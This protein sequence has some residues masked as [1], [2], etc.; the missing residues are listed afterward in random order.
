M[1]LHRDKVFLMA[2]IAEQRRLLSMVEDHPIMSISH[3]IKID[4]LQNELDSMPLHSEE[5]SIELLFSGKAVVGSEGIKASFLDKILNPFQEL[6]KKKAVQIRYGINIKVS[7][8]RSAFAD[9]YLT[10]LPKGSF[11]VELSQ[12]EQHEV[13]DEIQLSK[14]IHEVMK[15][16]TQAA[17]GDEAF[18]TL[19][20]S[21]SHNNLEN[22]R[23]F[24]RAIKDED[25]ILK[26]ASGL[27][28]VEIPKEGVAMAYNRVS[29]VVDETEV[30]EEQGIFKG[31]LIAS[32][33]FE[34]QSMSGKIISGKIAEEMAESKLTAITQTFYNHPSIFTL[35]THKSAY[36][37]GK[38][39]LVYELLDIRLAT[40]Q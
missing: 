11:G 7:K 2:Q 36:R 16:I 22:L 31:A 3:R 13:Q 1:S 23:K 18:D 20:E 37:T 40:N 30:I 9:L 12:V 26:M 32:G 25:S 39:K 38:D 10:H 27:E 19:L 4:R 6:V 29:E 34:F 15:M 8:K 35:R 28:S 17:G 24:L 21:T 33:K 5:P 14:A